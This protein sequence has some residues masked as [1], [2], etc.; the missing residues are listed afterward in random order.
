MSPGSV[1]RSPIFHWNLAANVFPTMHE[2][3]VFWNAAFRSPASSTS[4]LIRKNLS[5]STARRAKKFRGSRASLYV[6]P[7]HCQIMESRTPGRLLIL[8]RN[9]TGIG[10]VIDT[11]W[12]V[13][14]RSASAGAD[15]GSKKRER[16]AA[17]KTLSRQRETATLPTVKRLLRGFRTVLAT[18]TEQSRNMPSFLQPP[19]H[20]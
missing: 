12:W 19:W 6:P 18:I 2:D 14:K 11:R 3:R 15:S 9:D 17:A 16:Y 10:C 8:G 1:I 13:T 4:G 7:N 5:G 20:S